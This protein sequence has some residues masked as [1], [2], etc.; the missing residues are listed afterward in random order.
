MKGPLI[1]IYLL[2]LPLFL[3]GTVVLNIFT[4]PRKVINWLLFS[5][6]HLEILLPAFIAIF[7]HKNFNWPIWLVIYL[8]CFF[9]EVFLHDPLDLSDAPEDLVENIVDA[10]IERNSS[11]WDSFYHRAAHSH[12]QNLSDEDRRK[13][14][15]QNMDIIKKRKKEIGNI[16][17][18]KD[19]KD[20]KR[21]H[22]KELINYLHHPMDLYALTDVYIQSLP[23]NE[24]E[25]IKEMA[26]LKLVEWR[27]KS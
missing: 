4:K 3:A 19:F 17:S 23:V 24:L 1:P 8:F 14:F 12:L 25:K 13:W 18:G 2:F 27:R 21:I 11:E 7:L 15:E 9:Y 16:L 5:G 26:K 20:P 10:S 22:L 6:I